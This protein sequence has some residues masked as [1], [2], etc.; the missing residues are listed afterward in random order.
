MQATHYATCGRE[1]AAGERRYLTSDGALC[2][3]CWLPCCPLVGNARI[4]VDKVKAR[5]D[6]QGGFNEN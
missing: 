1:I 3:E 6:T 2:F 4:K 5:K